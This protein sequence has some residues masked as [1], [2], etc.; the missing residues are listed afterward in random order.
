MVPTIC[1][2]TCALAAGQP[3]DRGDWGLTPQLARGQ[4]FVYSGTFVEEALSP[5]VQ[6]QRS[7]RVDSTVLVLDAKQ[8]KFDLAVLTVVTGTTGKTPQQPG[9]K[10]AT[11]ASVRLEALTLD[12]LGKLKAARAGTLL[13]PVEGPPTLE[14]GAFVELP[15][16]RLG[17]QSSWDTNEEGRA[18]RTWRVDPSNFG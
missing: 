10:A 15:K 2:L 16:V 5:G 13:V 7:Y 18:P 4:E 14:C 8:D 3:P 6:F 12:K 11:P 1:L 17:P 9:A